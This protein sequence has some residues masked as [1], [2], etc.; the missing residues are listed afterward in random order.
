MTD[1]RQDEEK[2]R[3]ERENEQ[4]SA[5]I[6]ENRQKSADSTG[7]Q[8]QSQVSG[9]YIHP[10]KPLTPSG[11][12]AGAKIDQ[13]GDPMGRPKDGPLSPTEAA[14][15]EQSGEADLSGSP[16]SAGEYIPVH[17]KDE[18]DRYN[19]PKAED[20]PPLPDNLKDQR[21]DK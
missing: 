4:K 1:K 2:A 16:G 11:E 8:R 7:T 5:K 18:P 15:A 6:G 14:I 12:V 17:N 20:N 19:A 3:K 9:S 10:D 13:V 21:P